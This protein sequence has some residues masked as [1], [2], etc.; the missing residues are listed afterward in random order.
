M[1]NENTGKEQNFFDK[2]GL[3][4]TAGDVEIGK[5]YPIYGM[6]TKI[7][8]EAPGQVVVEFS[9]PQRAMTPGQSVVFYQDEVCLGGAIISKV[10]KHAKN[11]QL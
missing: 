9:A 4:V 7:L 1:E 6:I 11:L 3:E 8:S 10:E 5:T 2:F